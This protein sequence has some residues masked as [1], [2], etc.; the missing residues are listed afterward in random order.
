MIIMRDILTSILD[1]I[2]RVDLVTMTRLQWRLFP[3]H[4]AGCSFSEQE[5]T[6]GVTHHWM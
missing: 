3:V 2:T 4:L 1:V 6:Q 5:V